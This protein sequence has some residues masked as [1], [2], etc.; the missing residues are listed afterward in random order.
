MVL[1]ALWWAH[2]TRVRRGTATARD[3]ALMW[4]A[5]ALV[6]VFLLT[7]PFVAVRVAIVVQFQL[8]RVFWL[9]DALLAAYGVSAIGERLTA[10]GMKA[11][12]LAV[13]LIS[14][15]RAVYVIGLEHAERSL[16]Q[17][18]LPESPWLDAMRWVA[19]QPLD[20]YV[21][22]DPG[23]AFK[24]GV[25]VRVAAGRDVL[26]EDD[27][28]SSIALYNR[29]LALRVVERRTAMAGFESMTADG[30]RS[31]AARYGLNLLVTEATL[32]LPEVYRNARFRIYALK[33]AGP[34][35]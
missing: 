15:A 24:Y 5:T 17:I 32:D 27:K 28:D 25:S 12:A 21:L 9:V 29:D 11:L 18:S 14:T 2:T 20:A 35:S 6:V 4:G 31:L 7:L 13:L 10:R 26:L 22:A 19:R 3:T 30:A 8:S 33:P 16:F 23:H 1:G 34:A